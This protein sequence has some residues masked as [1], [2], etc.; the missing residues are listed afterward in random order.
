M[1]RFLAVASL[2]AL[3]ACATPPSDGSAPG[4]TAGASPEP[5]V[6]TRAQLKV[7]AAPA[8]AR[9]AHAVGDHRLYAVMGYALIFPAASRADADRL[10]YRIIA[11]TSDNYRS[12]EERAFNEAAHAW[13]AAWNTE[14]LRLMR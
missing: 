5:A 12:D 13:A 10:G 11:G 3:A 4:P 1:M 7:A 14:M 2:A 6:F 8:Q 9:R